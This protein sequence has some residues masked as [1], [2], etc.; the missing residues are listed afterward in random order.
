MVR[1]LK[2]E[3][4]DTMPKKSVTGSKGNSVACQKLLPFLVQ[5]R[6]DDLKETEL[7]KSVPFVPPKIRP[8]LR[9]G[10]RNGR[11]SLSASDNVRMTESNLDACLAASLR[12]TMP[13]VLWGN[14]VDLGISPGECE[15]P[16]QY[17]G[18]SHKIAQTRE[19][20]RQAT[21]FKMRLAL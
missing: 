16:S 12:L 8:F 17:F 4:Y 20:G 21:C 1:F 13:G 2:E 9:S 11:N 5:Q 15:I 19:S 10:F 18:K 3:A 7:F 6:K 14:H